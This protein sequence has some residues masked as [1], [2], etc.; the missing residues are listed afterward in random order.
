MFRIREIHDAVLPIDRREIEQVQEILRSRLP[1][2]PARE[3]DA[4]P[5]RL[6]D[7]VA[8][9]LRAMLLVAD[10]ERGRVKGF[11]LVSHAPDLDFCFLDYIAAGARF[12]GSG[13]GG[14]LYERVRDVAAALGCVGVFLESLPD[15]PQACPGGDLA[16]NRARL[17]FYERFGARPIV[18]TEYEAPVEAGDTCLPHLVF[19]DLGSGSPLPRATAR[20]V[21]RAI[22]ERKYA[23]LCPPE[24][25]DRVVRSF[26]DDPVRLRECRYLAG[27]ATVEAHPERLAHERIVLVVNDRHQIHHVRE[28]GYV[29]APARVQSILA[30]IEPTGMFR[31]IEPKR[32]AERHIRAVH[33]DG[34]VDYLKR[35][36]A[37]LEEGKS[38]Y[39]YVFPLRNATRP[40]RDLAVRAGYYCI[41]TFTPLHRNAWLAARRAVDCALTAA[42]ALLAGERLAYAL[43]RPPGHHAER[44]SFGGFCYFATAAIAA[45]HLCGEGPVA[46]LDLDYHHGNGQQ[47]IFWERRDVL[48]VSIHGD[49]SFAYPYF[50]GFAEEIGAG[51]G[52]GYNL[53]L[54]QPERLDGKGYRKALGKALERIRE[55]APR[56]LVVALGLD[57]AKADPT[58]TWSLDAGDLA[59]NGRAVGALRLPTLVV[60]EGGY[61]VRSLG[62]NARNFFLGLAEG[63]LHPATGA[64]GRSPR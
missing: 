57:T 10:D 48:T 59:A 51:K 29:E 13:V 23:H 52:K 17:R 24:Y 11:A 55:F 18:G 7:P 20:K 2:V 35:V 37:S 21:V 47:D 25:V 16:A 1:G 5:Q 64:R 60:Q 42:D 3:V 46:I 40:P 14:A 36:C 43:V 54:P 30:G 53:N 44:R 26:G 39:P 8:T 63:A 12:G 50:S 28:R 22:L 31:R 15:D 19:D 58:G 62:S 49:P 32:H 41:D 27:P 61:R 6:R 33:D 38:V 9:G 34:Y 45:A 4:L 56:F